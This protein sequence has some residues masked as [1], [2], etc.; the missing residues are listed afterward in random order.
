MS[1]LVSSSLA[2][3]PS[4]TRSTSPLNTWMSPILSVCFSFLPYQFICFINRFSSLN[5]VLLELLFFPVII[6]RS[7]IELVSN[8]SGLL[9]SSAGLAT[10]VGAAQFIIKLTALNPDVLKPYASKLLLRLR[11]SI[12]T[13]D[14]ILFNYTIHALM[15]L[16]CLASH[17]QFAKRLLRVW[18]LCARLLRIRRSRYPS[19]S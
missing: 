3:P 9:E 8:L 16:L 13:Y 14:T 11:R 1:K 10:R 17:L 2:S 6:K 15:F 4:T 19:F 5:L 18:A 12:K 7:H